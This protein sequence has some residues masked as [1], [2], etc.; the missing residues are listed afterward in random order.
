ML[1]NLIEIV[2]L[3]GTVER[4]KFRREGNVYQSWMYGMVLIAIVHVVIEILVER[5]GLHLSVGVGNGNDFVFCKLHGTCLVNINMSTTHTNHTLIL[6]EHRVNG[7]GV[8]LGSASQKEYL[9]VG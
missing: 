1:A 4:T 6:I 2:K 7:S 9:R 3:L 8:G 5:L